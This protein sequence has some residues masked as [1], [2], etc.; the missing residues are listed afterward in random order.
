MLSLDPSLPLSAPLRACHHAVLPF[1]L[2]LSLSPLPS[3]CVCVRLVDP[4]ALCSVH[5]ACFLSL[6]PS[7]A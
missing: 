7:L 2:P 5:V 3:L 6:L 1:F 4:F